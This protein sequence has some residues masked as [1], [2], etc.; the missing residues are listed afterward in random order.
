MK[1]TVQKFRIYLKFPILHDIGIST[2][3]ETNTLFLKNEVY[4]EFDY[5]KKY[6]TE[7]RP[8]FKFNRSVLIKTLDIPTLMATKIRA[9]L[10]RKWEKTDKKGRTIVRVKGRDY[11]DL[12][13]YLQRG[14]QPNLSC[15]EGFKYMEDLKKKLLA[16]VA[17]IDSRSIKLD[18]EPLIENPNFVK[19]ISRNIKTILERE[20]AEKL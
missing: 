2:R 4:T 8:I 1:A 3:G 13:W 11:F 19:N 12:L 17:G 7:I 5:C 6:S 18:L 10:F 16:I 9:I 15:I 14:I 20:I